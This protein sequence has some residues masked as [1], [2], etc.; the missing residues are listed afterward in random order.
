MDGMKISA[1]DFIHLLPAFMRDDNAVI[2]LSKAINELIQAPSGRLD[3]IRTWD[4]IDNLTE[5]ECDEMAWELAIDWYNSTYALDVKRSLIKNYLITKRKNGTK[6][7]LLSVLQSIFKGVNVEEWFE[8]GGQPYTFRLKIELPESNI[9]IEQQRELVENI[10]YYKSLRSHLDGFI[11]DFTKEP[12]VN[13]LDDFALRRFIQSAVFDDRRSFPGILLDGSVLLDGSWRLNS[14]PY[15]M[16]GFPRLRVSTSMAKNKQSLSRAKL[17]L[18]N[19]WCL[20]GSV[21]LDGS[22][23]LNADITQEDL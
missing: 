13:D 20:D 2:A 18:D 17:T 5:A 1:L 16:F 12:F 23:K 10:K 15:S 9:T 21:L 8:Y 11:W 6:A 14:A 7:S 3:T 19:M 22:R 4:Q